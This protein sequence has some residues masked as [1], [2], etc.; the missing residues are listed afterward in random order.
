MFLLKG[1]WHLAWLLMVSACFVYNCVT[2][3]LRYSFPYQTEGNWFSWFLCD[4]AADVVYLL[5][6]ILVKPHA[7]FLYD[8]FWVREKRLTRKHYFAKWQFKVR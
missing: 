5:D 4:T 2:I 3:P 6:L 7:I 8:G 1:Y